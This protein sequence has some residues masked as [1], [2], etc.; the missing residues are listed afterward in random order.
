[1]RLASRFPMPGSSVNSSTVAAFRSTF[2]CWP[3]SQ[4]SF[5]PSTAA[6]T[7]RPASSIF[8]LASAAAFAASSRIVFSRSAESPEQPAATTIAAANAS[9]TTPSPVRMFVTSLLLSSILRFSS[10]SCHPQFPLFIPLQKR[11]LLQILKR[12]LQLFLCVHHDRTVPR[13]RLL[14]RFPRHK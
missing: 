2:F 7:A 6:F 11:T 8:G 12:L 5:A 4:P 9:P 3:F 13:Y 10:S 1:M 14:E